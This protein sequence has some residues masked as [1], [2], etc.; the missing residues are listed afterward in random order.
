MSEI[1][2]PRRR[3]GLTPAEFKTLREG[4]GLSVQALADILE[5]KN[6]RTIR[7]WEAGLRP[8]PKAVLD[9]IWNL[10][11]LASQIVQHGIT[12]IL[13]FPETACIVVLR[14]ETFEDFARYH[15]E[16]ATYPHAHRI[17]AAAI[18][19]LSR[20]AEAM[21]REFRVVSMNTEAYEAWRFQLG[22]EDSEDVRAHWA[23]EELPKVEKEGE[24]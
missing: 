7:N 16:M 15:P 22:L 2:A 5:I 12:M 21:G 10:D 6:E 18:G 24:V 11:G 3:G 13:G 19:R 20:S 14:Y 17:H 4:L 8:L 23:A 9:S 1:H